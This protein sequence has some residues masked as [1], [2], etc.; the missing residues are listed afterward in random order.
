MD[1]NRVYFFDTTLRDG[2]QTPGVSLQTPEKIEIAKGLVRLG[3]D[4][5]EAGFPAAS[6]GDFEAVQTIAREVKGTTICGLA[7]ANEK[8][9]QKVA[10]A[11]KDAERSRLHVF[12]ATSEIH[13]KYKLKMTRQEVLDRVKSILEFAKGKFDEIEFSGEDAARTDL[14]FLC[15]VFGVAI[16]G[17][18]TI[19]NVPDTVGYMNPNEFGDKI[20]YIKEHTPGIENAIIS[21][22]CHDDL[23]LANANTLAAIKAGARQVEGTI[24]GLGERAGN[25]AIEEVVM[26]LKT[27][28]DYFGD[29][30]VNIDTKQ[31]TKVSK[32][33]SR[34]TGVVVPPNKPIVGS[35]AFAHESGIHQHGMMSNPETYEIM[36]PESVGAEKTDLV[37]GKHSG[38]HAFAD[39]LAKLGFQSFTEEEINAAIRKGTL[40][41]QINPMTCG[42]SFKNKGVQTLLDYVCAFL[43]SPLDTENVIG[44][45]PNTGAEEDR[46]PSDDEKTSALAFK[47]ATDPY[48]GRLTFFRV[49]SGKIEA[50]S[51]IYNSRSGKKERVSRLFQMHSNKQNPVE[52]IGAG[53]IGAGV[54]FKDIHTGDTLCDENAPIVL[55][56]MDFPEPVIG[57]AVEPKTQKDM[58][59]LSNGLAKLAEEDP[60]FTVKT[61]EQ[62]GQTVISGMGELH[63]DII[64]DRLKREFKVEC[65]QGKPQVNYKEAITKTVNLREVY[66]K[67]SGGRGKFADIIVNIGPADADFTLGG[68][69]FVDEVKGGNIPKEFIPAVQKGFTNAMKSG[70]LAGYPLDS[71]KVTLVDGSFHPVDSDQLSFEIC[72]MQAY[73]N[74]CAKAGPVLMEPIMKLEVVTPEE[75]MGD[76][77][78][79]LNKR[80]GQV[81]GM[82]SSR[83]GARIVKAMVPLAEMF[84]YVTA[85][86]TITSGRATSSMTYSHH[87]QLSSSIAKAVLEEVKGRADLL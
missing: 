14:D 3:I 71:L 12:I 73:K 69:Q 27:R 6:P 32:L 10:D 8:D 40:A 76:V 78:G 33:V 45:N 31:F 81:E 58:D 11:L 19:I 41:M 51:Y 59:K 24:N 21:V 43:P 28:H 47:I 67:Q 13:M 85:L 4:V 34:L 80:R 70:V 23:G 74:A 53:D 1:Q 20:R 30:Q 79:D 7:R 50:G 54:G 64:I 65:N 17:G 83:S 29:L 52:V 9:V 66:K 5:I 60:T 37:L 39:H 42:S 82:E 77:I 35:N 18:A 63:L 57:I 56:S 26:A 87:A 48:V 55:E 44:T 15:E 72:A 22:H 75:N 68:L 46:K 49:Y 38:R 61:D 36:T 84:G 2:E 62:T 86:R 16:A 25:V